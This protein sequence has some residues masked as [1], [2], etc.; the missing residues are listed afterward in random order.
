M[1]LDWVLNEWSFLM[2]IELRNFKHPAIKTA[3]MYFW[4][5][6]QRRGVVSLPSQRIIPGDVWGRYIFLLVV[7]TVTMWLGWCLRWVFLLWSYHF[8]LCKHLRGNILGLQIPFISSDFGFPR[9]TW[10]ATMITVV[11]TYGPF[12]IPLALPTFIH[13][14]SSVKRLIPSPLFFKNIFI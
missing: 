8:P 13:W 12:W 11:F 9:W 3:V 4:Q 6:P 10:P 14:N 5:E 7:L 1:S 2:N